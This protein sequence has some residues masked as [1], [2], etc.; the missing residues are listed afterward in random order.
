[1]DVEKTSSEMSIDCS[2]N[3]AV[4]V[5]KSKKVDLKNP[6]S[7]KEVKNPGPSKVKDPVNPEVLIE[8][9]KISSVPPNLKDYEKWCGIPPEF[10]EMIKTEELNLDN[11]LFRN[12]QTKE[13]SDEDDG[14]C[15]K[16]LGK[17]YRKFIRKVIS[18]KK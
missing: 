10:E 15:Q 17:E 9:F 1:M 3:D 14:S 11:S 8:S 18:T 7:S 5:K 6:G 16:N 12:H 13:E 4:K 2:S